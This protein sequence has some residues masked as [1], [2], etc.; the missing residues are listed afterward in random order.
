MREV[1]FG[2]VWLVGG[3][4]FRF[5]EYAALTAWGAVCDGGE[6]GTGEKLY[7]FGV[8]GMRYILV[9]CWGGDVGEGKMMCLYIEICFWYVVY[10]LS[11]RLDCVDA[12]ISNITYC[13]TDFGSWF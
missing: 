13:M 11:G 4:P 2:V 5:P 1:F 8:L 7:C 6:G 12:L 10:Y 9:G 3:Q